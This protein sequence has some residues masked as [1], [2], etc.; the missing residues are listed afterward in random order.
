VADQFDG[1]SPALEAEEREKW[2]VKS[3][4]VEQDDLVLLSSFLFNL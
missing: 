1:D 4:S 3:S 2:Q